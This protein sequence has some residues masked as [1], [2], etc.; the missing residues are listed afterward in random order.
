[1]LEIVI[2]LETIVLTSLFYGPFMSDMRTVD[3]IVASHVLFRIA[4]QFFM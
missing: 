3:S 2:G 1:M 4:L